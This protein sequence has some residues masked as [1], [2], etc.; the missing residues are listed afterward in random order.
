MYIQ[1]E[2]KLL[3]VTPKVTRGLLFQEANQ[4]LKGFIWD[5]IVS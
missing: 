2:E 1:Y 5:K 4:Y 3:C